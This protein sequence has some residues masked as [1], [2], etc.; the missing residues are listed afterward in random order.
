MRSPVFES[1][2]FRFYLGSAR[3]GGRVVVEVVVAM[4]MANSDDARDYVNRIC[5]ISNGLTTVA[6][7]RTY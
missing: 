3:E 5:P 1:Q 4:A 6:V 7:E 2:R